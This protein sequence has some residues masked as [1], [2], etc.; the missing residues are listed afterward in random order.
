MSTIRF[1]DL[2][3]IETVLVIGEPK[4]SHPAEELTPQEYHAVM[5]WRS[6][7]REFQANMVLPHLFDKK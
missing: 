7:P 4:H 2:S 5:L 1:L 6:I 3:P